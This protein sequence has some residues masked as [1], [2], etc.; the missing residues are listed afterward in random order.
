MLLLFC[1]TAC[2][3]EEN[4]ILGRP[5]DG[6]TATRTSPVRIGTATNW[7]QVTAGNQHSL[8][9]NTDGE[10]YAWGYNTSGQL[11]DGA[12]SNRNSPTRIGAATNWSQVTATENYSLAINA[13][14]ELYAWGNNT[15]GQLG[16]GTSVYQVTPVAVK[17]QAIEED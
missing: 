5:G 4:L 16:D 9:I 17:I 12:G 1:L 13:D 15:S 2:V 3:G 11:G 7:S 6:T 8:A 10:L 14:G